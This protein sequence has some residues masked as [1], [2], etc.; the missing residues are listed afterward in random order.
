MLMQ[1]KKNNYVKGGHRVKNPRGCK[2][3]EMDY[4]ACE[5]L[6]VINFFLMNFVSKTRRRRGK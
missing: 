5:L 3:N 2:V 4:G 6:V 1:I